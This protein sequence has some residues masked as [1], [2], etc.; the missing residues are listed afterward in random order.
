M[1]G[2]RILDGAQHVR[3]SPQKMKVYVRVRVNGRVTVRIRIRI[4]VV[5]VRVFRLGLVS[6]VGL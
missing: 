6:V 1:K 2:K 4:R 5:G 3:W